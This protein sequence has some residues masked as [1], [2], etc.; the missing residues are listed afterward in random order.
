LQLIKKKEVVPVNNDNIIYFTGCMAAYR[1][2]E[3]AKTTIQLLKKAGV[4]FQLLGGDEWCCG[5]VLLRTGNVKLAREMMDHN[6]ETFKNAGASTVVTSCAGCYRTISKDYPKLSES[7]LEFNIIQTSELLKQLIDEGKLK[8]QPVKNP[9]GNIKIT[10]HDPCH[11]GRHM[12]VYNPPRDVLKALPNVELVEMT[13]NRENARCCGYGGGVASA[14]K[15]LAQKMSDTRVN[16]AIETG[17]E[18]LTSACPFCTFSL[19]EAAE[20]NKTNIEVIDLTEVVAKF[21]D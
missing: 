16:D 10:Y 12:D 20:R 13:R 6:L 14:D 17:A 1:T 21:V 19:R 11:L 9:D 8:F 4:K 5:S 3:I 18:I 2:Q 15:E 7:E